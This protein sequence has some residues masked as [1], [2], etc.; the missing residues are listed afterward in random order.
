MTRVQGA[1][2]VADVRRTGSSRRFRGLALTGVLATLVAMMAT[3]LAAALARVV[4]VDFEIPEGGETIPLSGF[5]VVTGFFSLI[6]VVLAAALRRWSARPAE[7]FVQVAVSLT[8]ISLVPPL[9]SGAAAASIAALMVL[10][11]V[12]AAVMIPALSRS[13]RAP[14]RYRRGA[15]ALPTIASARAWTDGGWW[16]RKSDGSVSSSSSGSGP[17]GEGS[18][19]TRA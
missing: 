17:S 9:F 12:A 16:S 2:V 10:H 11:L 7:R 19:S 1:A 4:G 18:R 5:A 3:P 8:T 14:R 15:S 13:L 6:G